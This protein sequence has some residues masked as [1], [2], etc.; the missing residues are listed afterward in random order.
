MNFGQDWAFFIT[1][2][3]I[4]FPKK[5]NVKIGQIL[6]PQWAAQTPTTGQLRAFVFY[7]LNKHCLKNLYCLPS[8]DL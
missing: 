8:K 7:G 5:W 2:R 3:K 6:H 1:I 4:I